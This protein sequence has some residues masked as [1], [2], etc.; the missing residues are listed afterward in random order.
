MHE[1]A[2]FHLSFP[3]RRGQ[4]DGAGRGD[5]LRL[6]IA[7]GAHPRYARNHGTGEPQATA[8]DF[9]VQEQRVFHERDRRTFI[10]LP[11]AG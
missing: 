7:S 9:V 1:Q 2:P 5:R 8:T 10:T 3:H 4:S 6:L 11:V